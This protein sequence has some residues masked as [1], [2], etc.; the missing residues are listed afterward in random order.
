MTPIGPPKSYFAATTR[1]AP[2]RY[3]GAQDAIG[4]V[5]AGLARADFCGGYWPEHIEHVRDEAALQFVESSLYLL[6]LGPRT[7]SYAVLS[8]THIDQA[9]ARALANA[10]DLCWQAILARD[11][12]VFGQALKASFE[13][14]IAMFPHMVTPSMQELI[15]G[16]AQQAM[17]WKVSGAGGGGYLILVAEKPIQHALRP[18]AR[19]AGSSARFLS[20]APQPAVAAGAGV[21]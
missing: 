5:F 19:H 21:P 9:S 10:A 8:E 1:P 11:I 6:P 16:H 15:E 7:E 14:Q 12:Q 18:I 3:P 4:I 17:G 13:A 2:K 20:R